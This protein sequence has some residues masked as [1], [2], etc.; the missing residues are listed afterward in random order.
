MRVRAQLAS[1]LNEMGKTDEAIAHYE[2]MLRLNPGDN[3]GLR[4]PLLGCYLEL[5]DI[6]GAERI[7]T[8]YP[9]EGSAMFIWAQVLANLI[10]GEETAA[11]KALA[12]ARTANKHVEAYLIGSKKKPATGPGYYSPGE[13]SEAIVCIH[14]IGSAWTMH[15]K[16]ID[17]L[18]RQK[19]KRK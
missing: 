10:A 13:P 2:E 17:W 4:Y 5:G 16:A 6:A 7:F 3:Q 9:D 11:T 15:P 18:K 12:E 1:L 8:E 19:V 14:E